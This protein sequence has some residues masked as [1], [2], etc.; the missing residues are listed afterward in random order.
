MTTLDSTHTPSDL[1]RNGRDWLEF[2]NGGQVPPHGLDAAPEQPIEI[3]TPLEAGASDAAISFLQR[4][5]ACV[6]VGVLIV[7]SW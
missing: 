1:T 2:A 3:H 5:H 6:A 4:F 7:W